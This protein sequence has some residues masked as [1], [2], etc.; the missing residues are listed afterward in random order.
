MKKDFKRFHLK[1][2]YNYDLLP[3]KN[4]IKK[5]CIPLEYIPVMID[6]LH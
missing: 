5:G 6:F 2:V 1:S 4:E 3:V